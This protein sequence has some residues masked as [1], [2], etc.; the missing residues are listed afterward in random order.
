MLRRLGSHVM[1]RMYIKNAMRM[2]KNYT[3]YASVLI[4]KLVGDDW[5]NTWE[6]V[7]T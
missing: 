6:E 1:S 3:M 5:T 7:G 4:R 2:R